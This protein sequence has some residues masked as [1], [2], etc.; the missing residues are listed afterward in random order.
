MPFHGV[1]FF[2]VS[3]VAL[4][5]MGVQS[6]VKWQFEVMQYGLIPVALSFHFSFKLAD[7]VMS[8]AVV[9]LL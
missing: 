3:G 8:A 9:V 2:F 4:W 7:M 6:T 5:L 1:C